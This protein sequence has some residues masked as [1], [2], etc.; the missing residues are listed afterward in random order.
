[1]RFCANRLREAYALSYAYWL[2]DDGAAPQAETE[3][4][5]F[6]TQFFFKSRLPDDACATLQKT[7]AIALRR[8]R[9]R[10]RL[11]VLSIPLLVAAGTL[12]SFLGAYWW[13]PECLAHFRPHWA[14]F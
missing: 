9:P 13:V 2:A 3:P 7:D 11:A 4:V 14:C 10:I 8:P 1:M 6:A 5:K 12:A